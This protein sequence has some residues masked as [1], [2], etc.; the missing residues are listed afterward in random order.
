M[1]ENLRVLVV[2]T[3]RSLLRQTAF[4]LSEFG[5]QPVCYAD[6]AV[7]LRARNS[8]DCHFL[9]VDYDS[10]DGQYEQIEYAKHRRDTQHLQVYLLCGDLAEVDVELAIESG[11]DDF[12]RKPLSNGEILARL[13]AGAR[14]AEFQRRNCRQQWHD[15]LTGLASRTALLEHL[16][17]QNSLRG[18]AR[19]VTLA[20]LELDL[21]DNVAVVFG[22]DIGNEVLCTVATLIADA[23]SAGQIAAH[24][25]GGRFAVLLPD[26]SLEK[27][28]KWAEQIRQA[29]GELEF[30][31][32]D[33]VSRLTASV[34][35]AANE[36]QTAPGELFN[37]AE[38]ALA[39][40]HCSGRN[41]LACYGEFEEERQAWHDS[42]HNGNPFRSTLARDVMTPF[43]VTLSAE[44]PM[45][46]AASMF[47]QTR[48][49][50]LP[51]VGPGGEWLGMLERRTLADWDTDSDEAATPIRN[52]TSGTV[53]QLPDSAT[54]NA[55]MDAFV[56]HDE[57]VVVITCED[58]PQGF[59][60]REQFLALVR[61]VSAE[62]FAHQDDDFSQRTDYLVVPDVVPV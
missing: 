39:E 23:C 10:L 43:T 41:C 12:L 32:L 42:L 40:A 50:W 49:D 37:R 8:N 11:V 62:M 52:A 53:A 48:L 47:A 7:A 59:I 3:D 29:I 15:P 1:N 17:K 55:V 58:R 46:S 5:Y 24:L 36:E 38:A 6:V 34:G 25:S 30:A 26:H 33:P 13:R 18:R 21:F 35:L 61:P 27:A 20:V 31:V 45:A 14:Y 56:R 54:F 44:D 60:A 4:L 57:P 22:N 51:V 2:S 9:I 28:C 19:S 16:E